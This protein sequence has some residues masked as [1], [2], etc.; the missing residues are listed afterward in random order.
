MS[1]LFYSSS[2]FSNSTTLKFFRSKCSTMAV[3]VSAVVPA[4]KVISVRR[5]N[6]SLS[7][8]NVIQLAML[9][10]LAMILKWLLSRLVDQLKQSLKHS[11]LVLHSKIAL[12]YLIRC[13]VLKC[14]KNNYFHLEQQCKVVL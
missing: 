7:T 2:K 3:H 4:G 10:Y 6:S 8:S 13:C 1:H 12:K 11:S 5:T 9:L 14:R